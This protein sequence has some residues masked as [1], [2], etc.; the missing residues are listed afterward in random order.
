MMALLSVI[1]AKAVSVRLAA[2][3]RTVT[4]TLVRAGDTLAGGALRPRW[5]RRGAENGRRAR[6]YRITSAGRAWLRAEGAEIARDVA[7]IAAVL[8]LKSAGR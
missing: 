3:C 4:P 1:S 7:A 5:R 8:A 6:Y 2:R